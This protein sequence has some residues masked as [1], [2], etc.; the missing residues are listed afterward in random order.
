MT[1]EKYVAWVSRM[2][3]REWIREVISSPEFLTDPYYGEFG[4]ALCRRGQELLESLERPTE[5]TETD[6]GMVGMNDTLVPSDVVRELLDAGV[7]Q[8]NR[9]KIEMGDLYLGWVGLLVDYHKD[10]LYWLLSQCRNTPADTGDWLGEIV[11]ALERFG[12]RLSGSNQCDKK[13]IVSED[14][15]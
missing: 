5:T 1:N 13:L 2:D 8:R 15:R 9:G 4:R 6:G 12:A 14:V 7:L 11:L 3:P 10:N